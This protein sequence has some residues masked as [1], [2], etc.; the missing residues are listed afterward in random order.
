MM[1]GMTGAERAEVMVRMTF[2]PN[3]GITF[4]PDGA[5]LAVCSAHHVEVIDA[6]GGRVLRLIRGHA[7]MVAD[8]A[9]SPDGAVIVTGSYD[10]T[11][12]TWEVATGRPLVT[13]AGHDGAVYGVAF[14]PDGTR[15]ATA[16]RDETARVWDA[17]SGAAVAHPDRALRGR[18]GRGV[19]AGR[20]APGDRV[21]PE[22][23]WS[24][25]P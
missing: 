10:G 25:M 22:R 8:V 5:L 11:A 1:S 18:A 13:F 24:G 2:G 15:I 21:H 16:S 20:D 17:A 19:L 14:S 6:R 3:H 7:G 4:S 12:R 23:V 9:F